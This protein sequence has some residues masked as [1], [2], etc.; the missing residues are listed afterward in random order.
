MMSPSSL[1]YMKPFAD[2]FSL[3]V[4]YGSRSAVDVVLVV[5]PIAQPLRLLQDVGAIWCEGHKEPVVMLM[6]VGD[7]TGL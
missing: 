5:R 1:M 2:S 3:P 4:R 6:I 7:R